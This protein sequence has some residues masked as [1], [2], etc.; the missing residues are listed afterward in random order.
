MLTPDC[1][2]VAIT[3]WVSIQVFLTQLFGRSESVL[4]IVGPEGDFSEEEL[5]SMMS[6]GA[7][8]VGLGLNRLR[9]ETAAISMLVTAQT[10][11]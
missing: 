2:H 4:L 9:V 11:M 10:L 6:D 3:L 8:G 5:N 7:R 1:D